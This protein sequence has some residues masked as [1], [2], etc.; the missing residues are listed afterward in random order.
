MRLITK[1]LRLALYSA[2]IGSLRHAGLPTGM[3]AGLGANS[4]GRET[5]EQG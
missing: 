5:S 4:A 3:R 1:S 2:I